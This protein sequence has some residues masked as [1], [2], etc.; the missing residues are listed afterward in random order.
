M[1]Y[2]LKYQLVWENEIL[3]HSFNSREDALAFVQQLHRWAVTINGRILSWINSFLHIEFRE[4]NYIKRE[5]SWDYMVWIDIDWHPDFDSWSSWFIPSDQDITNILFNEWKI[6]W[7]HK[8]IYFDW[9]LLHIYRN[10]ESFTPKTQ[11]FELIDLI[12][13]FSQ[14]SNYVKTISIQSLKKEIEKK[15]YFK[16]DEEDLDYS[17]IRG[18]LKSR[19]ENIKTKYWIEILKLR[20]DRIEILI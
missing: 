6:T 10:K 13:T 4:K 16:L 12:F 8:N 18:I 14:E 15:E 11:L 2:Y 19:L 3:T 17:K 5:E 7:E 1:Y 9:D 20:K